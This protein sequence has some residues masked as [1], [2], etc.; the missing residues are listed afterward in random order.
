MSTQSAKVAGRPPRAP[1]RK[2]SSRRVPIWGWFVLVALLGLALSALAELWTDSLWFGSIGYER[3]FTTYLLTQV[4]LGLVGGLVVGGAVAATVAVALRMR[5]KQGSTSDSELTRQARGLLVRHRRGVVW[6][7][8]VAL[9]LGGGATLVSAAPE[10]LAWLHRRSFGVKD[11]T[12]GLDASFFVFTYPWLRRV[13]ELALLTAWASLICAVIVHYLTGGLSSRTLPKGARARVGS[14]VGDGPLRQLSVLAGLL[15]VVYGISSLLDR[16]SYPVTDNSF[17]TGVGYTDQNARISAHLIIAVI[18]FICAAMFFVNVFWRQWLNPVVA[19]VL[20]VLSS[21]VLSMIYPAAL[22]AIFVKPSEP[23]REAPFM[24]RHIEATRTAFGID[25]VDIQEYSAKTTATSG[26]LRAD[27]EALPG[28][29]LIDPAVVDVTFDQLQQVRGYYRFPS[30]LDVD[31]YTVDGKATD[32]V[33]AAREIDVAGLPDKNWNNVHTVYTHGFGLVAAYGNRRQPTGEPVWIAQDI[34]PTGK[35]TQTEARVYYGEK[36]SHFV[37][38]GTRDGEAPVELDTPGGG[39]RVGE[40]NNTYVGP[41]VSLGNPFVRTAYALT[42]GD[43]NLLLSDRVHS[44]SK[45][46]YRRTPIERVQ[47]VAP[48]LTVDSNPYPTL[49]DGRMVWVLDGYTTTDSFP[50]SQRVNMAEATTDAQSVR[51]GTRVGEDREVNYMRNAVKA[52][53]DAADGTVTLYAWDENDPIL[54]TW[55]DVFPGIV[56]DRKEISHSLMEHLR[57]PE[58]M[59]RVQRQVLGRYH[60]TDPQAWY[61]QADLWVVPED[62]VSAKTDSAGK[63]LKEPAYYLSIKWPGDPS[64]VFSLTSVFVPRGRNNLAAYMAVDAD[65]TSKG[66]GKLRVLRMSDTQQIAGPGQSLNAMT[67][68]PKVTEKLRPY[69]N[70]GAAKASYGNLL[71]IPV[72]GGLLYVDPVYTTREGESSS[73][74]PALRYVIV[75]FGEHVAIGETLQEALDSVFQGDSG[76]TTD[77]GTTTKP[78]GTTTTEPEQSGAEAVKEHLAKAEKAFVDADAA[79]KSGDLAAYQTKIAEAKAE[80]EAAVKAQG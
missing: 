62:P 63:G 20:M 1:R 2:G 44:A 73:S 40:Q 70:Q 53:V 14:R 30:V 38:V 18:A 64:P 58:D 37:V 31:R 78:G 19:V 23:D 77:E 74:Y 36:Q 25:D 12:F 71:T 79:L 61:K 68:D 60:M 9:G 67:Q 6:L 46:L 66:Y 59:F 26:Q 50:N 13:M 54:Q 5:P 57:Y 39:S 35:L 32:A 11:P 65:P 72:G 51:E 69:L 52:T 21:L 10:A 49:V 8:A 55:R 80:V 76:A 45:I 48:W 27:A 7:P 15:L 41:G 3:V 43:M 29:R 42:L 4:V 17:F 24:K 22:Q 33:V 34:P 75:R 56:K 47:A 28:I 16:V